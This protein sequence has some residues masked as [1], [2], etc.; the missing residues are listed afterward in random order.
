MIEVRISLLHLWQGKG[1]IQECKIK[2][3]RGVVG[4]IHYLS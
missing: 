2:G 1:L 4:N 3:L